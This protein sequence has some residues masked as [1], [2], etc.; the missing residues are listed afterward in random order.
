MYLSIHVCMYDLLIYFLFLEF[1]SSFFSEFSVTCC[2]SLGGLF[3][4][5]IEIIKFLFK[6]K[7]TDNQ[8]VFYI[9][10]CITDTEFKMGKAN[11]W[12]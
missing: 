7:K 3:Y 1:M 9:I 11:L 2:W 10:I 8:G 5:N 12:C 6:N 4:L